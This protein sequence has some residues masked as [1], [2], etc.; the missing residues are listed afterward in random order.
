MKVL[1][2]GAGRMGLRHLQGLAAVTP[3]A[4]VVD[5]SEAARD[6]AAR[7]GAV[8]H[9]SI[10]EALASAGPFDAAV[11]G[12]T[13]AGRLER[14]TELVSAGVPSLLLEKPVEQSR[15]RVHRLAAVVAAGGVDARVNHFFRTLD[16][17][18][19]LRAAGGPFQVSVVGGAFGLACNGIHWIDLA[20][21]LSGDAPGRL[22]FGELDELTIASGRGEEFC[23][24]GGR[25]LFAYEDGSWLFLASAAA[26]SAPMQATIVQPTRETALF[27]HESRAI[28]SSRRPGSDKP[29]FLYGADYAQSEREALTADALVGSTSAWARCVAESG[30]H[31][32]PSLELSVT[33]HDLLFDLLET[34]G[35]TDFAVT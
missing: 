17:F 5:P 14:V 23:D 21:Y 11:L 9:P 12:E 1:L 4:H 26:S 2:V 32:H 19:E 31:R 7:A 18:A 10:A 30:E 22:A 15:E 13:A 35:G 20:L 29:V 8:V 34:G 25:G 6:T 33:A 3:D 27:P 16:L 28:V 24:Y